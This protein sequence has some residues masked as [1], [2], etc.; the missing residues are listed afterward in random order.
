MYSNANRV[1]HES[2]P[3]AKIGLFRSL[4]SPVYCFL[5]L[6]VIQTRIMKGK[7]LGEFEELVLLAVQ[8]LDVCAY[9]VAVKV[10]LDRETRRDISLGAVYAAL[11]RLENKGLVR[12]ETVSGS[13]IRGGR[14]RRAFSLTAAGHRA[15]A[16]IERVRK[17]LWR[18]AGR[19][20]G[21]RS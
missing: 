19:P 20:A 14:R 18:L 4:A 10:V 17:R 13:P 21:G 1:N 15:L 12:S 8:G 9:G 16:E 2:T 11:G 5:P 6:F 3:K 7:H